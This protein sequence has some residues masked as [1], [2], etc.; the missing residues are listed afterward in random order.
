MSGADYTRL[1]MDELLKKFAETAKIAGNVFSF[2]A[3]KITDPNRGYYV[4]QMQAMGAEIRN[5][6]LRPPIHRLFEDA[7]PDVRGW[8]AQQ[9]CTF[10]PDWASATITGLAENLS[11]RAVLAWRDRVLQEPPK[12]PTVGEM[13]VSQLV[14]RF[15]DAA[16]RCYA[17]MR[18]LDDEQGGGLTMKAYNKISGEPYAV[19]RELN[20]RN[21]LAALV[22]LLHHPIITVRQKAASYC[23]SV[24]A[25]QAIGV[26]EEIA[27][28]EQFPEDSAAFWTLNYWRNGEYCAFP[29]DLKD[30][31][32]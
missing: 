31:R 15:V 8:A 30:V 29:A 18:F 3:A 6:N 26:L 10:D 16:E 27:K 32:V 28:G 22:P 12:H 1:S 24:A 19:A 7:D 25:D 23:L 17:A 4:A 2:N 20:A 9:F 14:D 13:T 11:T 5:R 21:R